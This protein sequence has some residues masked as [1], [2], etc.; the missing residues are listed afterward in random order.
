MGFI[1]RNYTEAESGEPQ[2]HIIPA[3]AV[4]AEYRPPAPEGDSQVSSFVILPVHRD[5]SVEICGVRFRA[6]REKEEGH[7]LVSY[8]VG[9]WLP[10][11]S[12]D[13]TPVELLVEKVRD[14][15]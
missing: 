7:Y 10:G 11:W 5:G 8:E 9:I 14:H 6:P 4:A 2:V 12:I 13:M 15:S 1:H 3:E